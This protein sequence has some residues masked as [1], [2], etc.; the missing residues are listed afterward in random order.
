MKVVNLNLAKHPLNWFVIWSMAL[1]LFF[2][3]HLV[4]SYF[5]GQHPGNTTGAGPGTST[6]PDTGTSSASPSAS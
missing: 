1:V 3:L 5:S 2:V 6:S 4:Q